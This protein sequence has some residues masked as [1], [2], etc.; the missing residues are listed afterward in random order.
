MAWLGL[1]ILPLLPFVGVSIVLFDQYEVL[2]FY[3]RDG[4]FVV[5][6]V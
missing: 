4:R 2:R 3:A 1:V 6:W 5:V